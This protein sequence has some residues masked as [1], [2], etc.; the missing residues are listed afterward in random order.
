VRI[1]YH[2]LVRDH[3][4]EMIRRDGS[5]CEV[6]TMTE[7]EYRQALRE[8]LIEEACEAA[9]A[10]SDHLVI[11]LADLAEVLDALMA[12]YGIVSAAV[13]AEQER[14]RIERGGFARRIRLLWTERA[15]TQ[16]D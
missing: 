9:G 6:V 11:E 1:E 2:K 10:D 13:Q 12:S 3:I 7:E 5:T 16:S 8:K 15:E 4:P 14:R